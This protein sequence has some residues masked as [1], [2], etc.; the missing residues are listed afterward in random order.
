MAATPYLHTLKSIT[1]NTAD[2]AQKE[3][4]DQAIKAVGFLPNM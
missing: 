2:A 3:I 1:P 4:L